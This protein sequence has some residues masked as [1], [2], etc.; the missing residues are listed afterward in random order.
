MSAATRR[1]RRA[2]QTAPR[3][4][5]TA[6]PGVA[7]DLLRRILDTYATQ[8]DAPA[9]EIVLSGFGEQAT[10]VRDG[11][12]DLAI[13]GSP[14]DDKGLDVEPLLS[15]PRVAALPV[16]HEL[17]HRTTLS[18]H[19]IA[20]LPVPRCPTSSA[21]IYAYWSGRDIASART[22]DGMDEA[23]A[24][25]PTVYDSAQL[26]EAVALGQAVALIPRSLAQRNSRADI[27]YRPVQDASPYLLGIA[28]R[29]GIRSTPIARLVR[30]AIEITAAGSEGVPG[31]ELSG[32]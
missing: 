24:T 19:D 14:F 28:W 7:T 18:C 27:A 16:R 5:V 30:T 20:D 23:S 13:V 29:A 3:L 4:V 6:K 1:T 32:V 31:R 12:A 22:E 10:M 26:L 15:E 11:R 8:P 17:T 9:T 2:A 25:G 21:A